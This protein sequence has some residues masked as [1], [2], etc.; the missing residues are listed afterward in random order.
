MFILCLQLYP[1]ERNLHR[2]C[3]TIYMYL[4]YTYL[5]IHN[6]L[7][8]RVIEGKLNSR[9]HFQFK[10]AIVLMVTSLNLTQRQLNACRLVSC[11]GNV[12]NVSVVKSF[13]L[14]QKGRRFLN[15]YESE[16]NKT[17]LRFQ[18]LALKWFQCFWSSLYILISLSV[19]QS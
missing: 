3:L 8:L 17:D 6:I 1:V 12:D 13:P 15:A 2:S 11:S 18:N 19:S 9:T 10:F 5:K 7:S 4:A 14:I 16:Q